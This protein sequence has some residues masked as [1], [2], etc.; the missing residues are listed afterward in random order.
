MLVPLGTLIVLAIVVPWYAALYQQWGW[1]PIKSFFFGE[2]LARYV[3]GVGVNTDRPVWWYLP[4]VFSDSFPWSLFLFPAGALWLR[5]RR[6]ATGADA[7]FRIQ[8]LLWIWILVIVAF[9]SLSAGKQ[10]LYI[11]PIVP[12]IV[13]LAGGVIARAA[14]PRDPGAPRI[15][16]V[17]IVIGGL[18]VA[19]GAGFLVLFNSALAVYVLAGS[20]IV[21]IVAIAGGA[22]A[23]LLAARQRAGAALVAIACALVVVNW[24]FVLKVLPSFEAYKPAPRLAAVLKAR[25]G[26]EDLIV[27]YN[28]ALPSLVYYLRRHTDVFYDHGPVVELLRSGRPLFLMVSRDDYERAIKPDETVPLCQVSSQ[29]TFDVKL[30]NVL[31]R[32]RPPEILLLTNKCG[33]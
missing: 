26:A 28:V 8:T 22:V 32:E 6:L 7:A 2:N 4:V 33:K 27:T 17:T 24:V 25:A 13:A 30:K 19:A 29:P 9:F 11:Y 10:D 31:S 1:A 20:P 15:V 21:G 23:M 14:E 3:D 18:L 16:P 12:A 5:T